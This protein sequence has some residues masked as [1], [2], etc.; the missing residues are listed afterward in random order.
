[1]RVVFLTHNYP[2]HAGDLPGAFLHPLAVAL[3][4]RG[5]DVRVVAPSDRGRNGRD[6]LDGVPVRRVRY[7]SPEREVFAYS[8]RM[9]EAVR[10]PGGLLALAD[11][12]LALKDGAEEELA[13]APDG[14]VIHAHWWLTAG[15]ATPDP[16][17]TLITV[18]GTDGRLL[19]RGGPAAWVGRWVLGRARL[20]SVVSADLAR[21]VAK[22]AKRADAAARVLPMPVETRD[23]PWTSGG[24][25]AI[26]VA[27]LT[28]QKRVD[29]G[30]RAFTRVPAPTPLT[31]VGDGPV[32]PAL[33]ELTGRLGLD[34]RVRFAGARP[35]D[36]VATLLGSADLM[37]FPA[38]GEGLGLAAVEA[39]MAGVPVVVCRDGGGVVETVE[40]W[41][42]GL[43]VEAGEAALGEAIGRALASESLRGEARAAGTRWREELTPARVAETFEGW[44]R[45]TLEAKPH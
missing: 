18:H 30:I 40:R 25:G 7:G 45:E 10:S 17:R 39:L 37:L 13:G 4:A 12:I 15:L 28:A 32:L 44:Y 1:M 16:G 41:G 6:E 22:V 24:G 27:R 8:G 34:D 31:I 23:R 26:I 14:G 43:T 2:R 36:E 3:R 19:E 11:L 35:P 20:V 38:V 9:A 29:L 5:H 33:R 21:V 42:G